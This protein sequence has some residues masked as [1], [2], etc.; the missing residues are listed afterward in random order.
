MNNQSTS[1]LQNQN[2]NSAL[3]Q[4]FKQSGK[5][6]I[7][8]IIVAMLGMGIGA[9]VLTGDAPTEQETIIEFSPDGIRF[10]NRIKKGTI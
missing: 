3:G 5:I 10:E 6:A 2:N 9:M 1:N 8:L 7:L 4:V